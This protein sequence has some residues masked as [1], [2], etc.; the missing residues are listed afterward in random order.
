VGL[1]GLGILILELSH[2]VGDVTTEDVA[3]EGLSLELLGLTVVSDETV[4]R[5]GDV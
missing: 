4:H 2:V 1:V 5:V 3:A